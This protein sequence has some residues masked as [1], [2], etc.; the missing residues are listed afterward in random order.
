[1]VRILFCSQSEIPDGKLK[2]AVIAAQHK[3]RWL[4]CRHRLRRSWEIPGGHRETGETIEQAARRE[5]WE[6]TGAQRFA[7]WPVCVYGV[8]SGGEISYG[9]LYFARIEALGD[10]PEKTEIGERMYAD[11]PPGELTYPEI[12][13]R[14][15]EKV[16]DWLNKQA[17]SD[18]LWDLYDAGRK[19]TGRRQR[20]GE[21]MQPGDY[22]LVVHAWL[23]NSRGEFL[24]TKRTPN[25]GYPNLWECPGGSAIAGEDSR[26]AAL[27]EVREETGLALQPDG[28]LRILEFRREDSFLDVWLFQQD[29]SLDSILLQEEETCGAQWASWEQLLSM[30]ARCELVPISYLDALPAAMQAAKAG[31]PK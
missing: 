4:W 2:Y 20:R 19:L 21:K 15:F 13:P 28:G 25:K 22:R 7:L 8:D 29:F 14:L 10:L 3:T 1:M 16:Q 6:E 24:L 30:Q 18:E 11:L 12:Q 27:R 5:L 31:N 9:M 17:S 26:T 23:Q